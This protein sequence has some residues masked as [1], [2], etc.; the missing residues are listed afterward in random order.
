[1]SRELGG[2]WLIV[3]SMVVVSG[4][5]H[6]FA[7]KIRHGQRKNNIIYLNYYNLYLHSRFRMVLVP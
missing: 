4:A 1:M 7:P 5:A 3:A 2:L 6:T